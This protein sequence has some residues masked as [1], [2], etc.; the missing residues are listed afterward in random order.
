MNLQQLF[1]QLGGD[2]QA[3]RTVKALRRSTLFRDVTDWSAAVIEAKRYELGEEYLIGLGSGGMER[4]D[5]FI[6]RSKQPPKPAGPELSR[7]HR[8]TVEVTDYV[9]GPLVDLMTR[10]QAYDW[11]WQITYEADK[12]TKAAIKVVN[13]SEENTDG[14]ASAEAGAG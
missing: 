8:F 4:I 11:L 1:E 3:R 12:H 6:R 9:D 7:T 14:F 5:A 2:Q 13:D 10:Q